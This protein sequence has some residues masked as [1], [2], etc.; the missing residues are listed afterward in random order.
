MKKFGAIFMTLLFGLLVVAATY[1]S[2]S[3]TL[4]I[5]GTV[6][7]GTLNANITAA[8]TGDNENLYNVGR[9][10]YTIDST[11]KSATITISNAYPGYVAWVNFSIKN[12]GTI[13]IK[14]I[15][16]V[17]NNN[18]DEIHVTTSWTGLDSN[19]VLLPGQTAHL[20]VTTYVTN[21]AAQNSTYKFTV[22]IEVAQFNAP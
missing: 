8:T 5:S 12:T 14:L 3:Q 15:D 4:S 2:W 11:Q 20:N 9:V 19:G 21:S 17:N 13:P 10:S 16:T 18:S 22:R 6:S 1:A 7:T